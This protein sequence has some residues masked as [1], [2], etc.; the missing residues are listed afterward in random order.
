MGKWQ[1]LPASNVVAVKELFGLALWD[2][3]FVCFMYI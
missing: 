3:S 1:A 2:F